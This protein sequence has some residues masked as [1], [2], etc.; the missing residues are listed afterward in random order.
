MKEVRKLIMLF[1]CIIAC[2]IFIQCYRLGYIGIDAGRYFSSKSDVVK[3]DVYPQNISI[4]KADEKKMLIIYSKDEIFADQYSKRID[5]NL[6]Y[7]KINSQ[8]IDVTELGN[9]DLTEYETVISIVSNIEKC[10][11]DN[12]TEIMEYIRNGG[13]MLWGF[14]PSNFS[15]AWNDI[16][17]ELGI[18]EIK[19][20]EYIEGFKF[21]E[22]VMPSSKGR[23]F[24][25]EE[26]FGDLCLNVKLD[27]ECRVYIESD[28]DI[29]GI[30]ILW[31]RKAG[32]GKIFFVFPTNFPLIKAQGIAYF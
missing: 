13:K 17:K 22:N 6:N 14:V 15:E 32:N 4:D 1:I 5:K 29:E 18:E 11:S 31:E 30:P 25:D 21:I 23:L 20:Y 27:D 2:G 19:G 24:I 28:G 9:I 7:M 3:N 8:F 16:Y 12:I 10:Y 26:V